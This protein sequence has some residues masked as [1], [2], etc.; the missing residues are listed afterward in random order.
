MLFL[1]AFTLW[2]SF[3]QNSFH[4]FTNFPI[5][6]IYFYLS[7]NW[8]KRRKMKFL[9]TPEILLFKILSIK[10]GPSLIIT[11]IPQMLANSHIIITQTIGVKIIFLKGVFFII[12]WWF[13]TSEAWPETEVGP[14]FSKIYVFSSEVIEPWLTGSSVT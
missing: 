12:F 8:K 10:L 3:S 9:L 5:M 2:L 13:S 14:R 4:E 7:T 6:N 11:R 1:A